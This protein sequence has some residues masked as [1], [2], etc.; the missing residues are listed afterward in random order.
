MTQILF[1]AQTKQKQ[2]QKVRIFPFVIC[3]D[4]MW[5]FIAILPEV[6]TLECSRTINLRQEVKTFLCFC[7]STSII[8]LINV[9]S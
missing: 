7:L 2:Q 5:G 8:L 6:Y 9:S 1:V 4:R 3:S